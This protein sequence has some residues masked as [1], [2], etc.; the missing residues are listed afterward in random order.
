M[1]ARDARFDEVWLSHGGMVQRIASTYEADREKARELTQE[2]ALAL[3]RALPAFRGEGSLKAFIARIAHNRAISHV[4]KAKA[5]PRTAEIDDEMPSAAPLAEAVIM[6]NDR[7]ARLVAAV[8][9]LPIGYAQVVSLALEDF[10]TDEIAATLG[11]T[12]GNVAVRMT[13]AKIMLKQTLGS[14]T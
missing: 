11:L 14:E 6:D 5:E 12:P 10:S 2:I 9:A 7:R 4:V 8:R 13:R 3:W 1:S